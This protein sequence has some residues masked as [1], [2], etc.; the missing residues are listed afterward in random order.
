VLT[1]TGAEGGLWRF[2]GRPPQALVG[3]GMTSQG[4]TTDR[5]YQRMPDSRTPQGSWVFNGIPPSAQIGTAD[6]LELPGGAAGG[7]V[8][9]VD[10]TIGSPENT[11]LL[12]RASNFDAAYQFVVEEVNVQD[13]LQSGGVNPL[14]TADMA[15]LKYLGGGAAFSVGSLNWMGSLLTTNDTTVSQVTQN[16][17]EKFDSSGPL[18]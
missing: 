2:R 10:Y 3:V 15:L 8:D 6:G 4:F 1:T 7:E 16:V 14:I 13:S 9:R 18:P 5:P 17:L 11:L 12:A